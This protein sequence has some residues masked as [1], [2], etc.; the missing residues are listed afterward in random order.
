MKIMKY[1]SLAILALATVSCEEHVIEYNAE[2]IPANSAMVQ[3][4]Y[5]VPQKAS[6]SIS[7]FK[8]ELDGKTY[9]NN[10]AAL[11]AAYGSYPGSSKY[12]TVNSGSVTLK[13]YQSA[14]MFEAYSNTISDLKA[15]KKYQVV[16]HDLALP[17][18][19]ID[20][21]FSFKDDV[22]TE[23]NMT[24]FTAQYHYKNFYNFLYEDTGVP[25]TEGSLQYQYRVIEDW[26][27]YNAYNKMTDAEKETAWDGY[28]EWMNVGAPVAFGE[29]TG[30]Q[31][32]TVIKNPTAVD[33][34]YATAYYRIVVP[35]EVDEDGNPV[36][37]Q[38]INS[39][40]TAY[41]NY[42]DYW[43]AYGGRHDIHFLRGFRSN[44]ASRMAVSQWTA[45]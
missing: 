26:D 36:I 31:K 7:I 5:M 21:D 33:A 20:S 18:T 30:W 4:H 41:V 19:V 27:A 43:T 6:T 34:N 39:G 10:G 12:Y 38:Y 32:L 2:P 13:L 40:G 1:L 44:T 45:Y 28:T 22:A 17:P 9:V 29:S 25:Y 16:V 37:F 23:E 42:S 11:M 15:G 8:I 3:I 14:D 24:E 35:G